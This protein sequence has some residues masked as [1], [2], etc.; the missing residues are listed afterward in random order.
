MLSDQIDLSIISPTSN[1]GSEVLIH[2]S[3]EAN[4]VNCDSETSLYWSSI[5]FSKIEPI[6]FDFPKNEPVENFLT[7][8]DYKTN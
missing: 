8:E 6:H 5:I 7:Y 3:F 2:L 4:T 1:L